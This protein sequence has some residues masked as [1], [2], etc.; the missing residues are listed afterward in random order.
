MSFWS[1]DLI[2]FF[3]ATRRFSTATWQTSLNH[4]FFLFTTFVIHCSATSLIHFMVFY[5][6]SYDPA[7]SAWKLILVIN[8]QI[9]NLLLCSSSHP[10]YM[11]E[12]FLDY[13]IYWMFVEL[14]WWWQYPGHLISY[15]VF[16]IDIWVFH[17]RL[18]SCWS[19]ERGCREYFLP[20]SCIGC[21]KAGFLRSSPLPR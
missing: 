11:S 2:T 10:K 4:L 8:D 7:V 6:Y 21:S 16:A 15:S 1:P 17:G 19:S 20:G 12:N 18:L 9:C 14:V 13:I 3:L 5:L